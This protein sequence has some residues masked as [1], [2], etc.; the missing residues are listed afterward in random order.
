MARDGRAELVRLGGL[1]VA[2]DWSVI[3]ASL[4][5]WLAGRQDVRSELV[6]H[7]EG[8]REEW[9]LPDDAWPPAASVDTNPLGPDELRT[10]YPG[11]VDPDMTDT[12]FIGYGCVQLLASDDEPHDAY[13]DVWVGLYDADGAAVVGLWE[14]LDPD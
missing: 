11:Q 13:A 10:H 14:V 6:S 2:G 3:E 1:L 7:I 5:P 12:S 8:M 4:S 9:E